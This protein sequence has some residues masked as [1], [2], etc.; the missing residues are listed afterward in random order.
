MAL[1]YTGDGAALLDVPARD[2]TDEEIKTLK[3]NEATLLASGL[4]TRAGGSAPK[5]EPFKPTDSK[6]NN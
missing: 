1:K 3:L 2:L 5:R 4:Y 6:E